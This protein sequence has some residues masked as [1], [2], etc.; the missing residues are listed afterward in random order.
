[1]NKFVEISNG[2]I[3]RAD[4]IVAI[5]PQVAIQTDRLYGHPIIEVVAYMGEKLEERR[6]V[7]HRLPKRM[8]SSAQLKIDRQHIK[9]TQAIATWVFSETSNNCLQI[10]QESDFI[11]LTAGQA[12]WATPG[13]LGV[14]EGV[15]IFD[16][17][18]EKDK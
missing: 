11:T 8:P 16:L 18:T 9:M 7:H 5:S 4:A 2:T 10:E 3:Y 14:P 12:D 1:M 17:R 15:S 6:L 13:D